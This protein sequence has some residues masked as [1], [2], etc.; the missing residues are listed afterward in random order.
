MAHRVLIA[1]FMHETNT[2]SGLPTS[3]DSFRARDL[4]YG[5]E[6]KKVFRETKTEIAAFLDAAEAF[7]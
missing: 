5:D 4:H 2:F 1:G 6:V 3:L 7:E